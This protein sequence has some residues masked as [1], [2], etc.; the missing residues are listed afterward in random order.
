MLVD[1][2]VV[3][4]R[5]ADAVLA[6]ITAIQIEVGVAGEIHR[7]RCIRGGGEFDHQ[8]LLFEPVLQVDIQIAGEALLAVGQP[9]V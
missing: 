8:V 7:R 3:I 1:R 2:Q 5:D 6:H 4:G 9:G